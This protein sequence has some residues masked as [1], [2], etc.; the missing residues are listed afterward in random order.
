MRLMLCCLVAGIVIGACSPCDDGPS[1][2]L[3]ILVELGSYRIEPK[4]PLQGGIAEV[5]T[6]TVT[7]EV[8][9][10]D[11]ATVRVS[12]DASA[13]WSGPFAR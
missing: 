9:T 12:Y 8:E 7:L 3:D 6:D 1:G 5:E 11:G 13:I 10:S 2:T 4:G